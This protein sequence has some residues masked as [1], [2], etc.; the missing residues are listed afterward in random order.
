MIFVEKALTEKEEAAIGAKIKALETKNIELHKLH[1]LYSTLEAARINLVH[2]HENNIP[3]E[4]YTK[5]LNLLKDLTAHETQHVEP[6]VVLQ[7]QVGNNDQQHNV[8]ISGVS[9]A[10]EE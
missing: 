10:E 5:I 1:S 2:P 4:E 3:E 8:K 6:I 7:E 9:N